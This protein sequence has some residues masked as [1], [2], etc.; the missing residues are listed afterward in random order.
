[1]SR[2][3]RTLGIVLGSL[4]LIALTNGTGAELRLALEDRVDPSPR[5]M[6]L[7]VRVAGI[8]LGLAVSWSECRALI[9]K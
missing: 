8:A 6:A 3:Q 5:Q 4:G 9:S 1:M 2:C 7:G